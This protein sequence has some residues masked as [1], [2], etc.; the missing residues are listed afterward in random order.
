[1]MRNIKLTI[2]YD[3]SRYQGWQSQK[4]TDNTIQCKL[5]TLL[6]KYLEEPIELSA[7]GRTDAGVHALG[8]VANFHTNSNASI[9]EIRQAFFDYLPQDIAV[10]NIE[11]V[12]SRFH[13][14]F[15]A[16]SKCYRYRIW[17]SPLLDVFQRNYVWQITE[18]LNLEAML[19]ATRFLTGTHDYISFCSNKHMKKSSVR[20]VSEIALSYNKIPYGQEI[21]FDFHGNG[22]L[23]NMVRIMTG[24]LVEVGKNKRKPQDMEAILQAKNRQAAGMTAPPMGLMLMYV[25]Y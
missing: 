1:M 5:E 12:D 14:R 4:H 22:F 15:H 18:P 9:D 17:N 7:S 20:T 11:E 16:V 21:I 6:S 3:G 19:Q 10:T 24:T 13:S 23:Y 8:Q 2:S 25:N